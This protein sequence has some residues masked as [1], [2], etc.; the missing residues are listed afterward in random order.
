MTT[1]SAEGKLPVRRRRFRS[2]QAIIR[3]GAEMVNQLLVVVTPSK[4]VT[5]IDAT[6]V[7]S[8]PELIWAIADQPDF[9]PGGFSL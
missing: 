5:A 1:E 2:S 8:L 7:P 4:H 3:F 6:R 9:P